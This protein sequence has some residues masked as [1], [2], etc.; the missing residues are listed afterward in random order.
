MINSGKRYNRPS[1]DKRMHT[2]LAELDKLQDQLDSIGAFQEKC[3][4]LL[5]GS[6]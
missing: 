4:F 3:T 5:C 6:R 2:L 1:L